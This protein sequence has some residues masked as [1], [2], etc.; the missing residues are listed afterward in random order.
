MPWVEISQAAFTLGV[1]ERTLRNW[2]KSGKINAKT[3]NGKRLV[4][5][6]EEE[7]SSTEEN[8]STTGDETIEDA[9]S[10]ESGTKLD[11]QK[12]L[13]V[14]LLEC[15]RVKGTL[16][17]QERIMETLSANIAE[18][19]A[20]L[21][22]SQNRAWKL[23]LICVGV[24]FIGVV[25]VL[26]RGSYYHEELLRK[27]NGFSE[28]LEVRNKKILEANEEVTKAKIRE[29]ETKTKMRDEFDSK[30]KEELE[31]QESKTLKRHKEEIDEL[32]TEF[33]A[34]LAKN[35]K[36]IAEQRKDLDKKNADLLKLSQVL[37]KV[38]Q[39]RDRLQSKLDEQARILEDF[40][41]LK[42]QYRDLESELIDSRRKQARN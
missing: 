35:D 20:K 2:I 27:T 4:D 26:M 13:E 15:G 18:L 36:T 25:A 21:Q 17:S 10:D 24:A 3:E 32:K 37:Q 16:A 8:S 42:K 11:T 38:T 28:Q 23:I 29:Y 14:A 22:K 30:L 5:I 40:D 9:Y 41:R 33:R 34:M 12:R 39:E 31:H 1:S 6:P 7:Y 19:T